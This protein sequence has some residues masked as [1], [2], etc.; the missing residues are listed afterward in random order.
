MHRHHSSQNSNVLRED[1]DNNDM[2]TELLDYSNQNGSTSSGGAHP[3]SISGSF[4]TTPE[5][6]VG[7]QQTNNLV[8]TS[9]SYFYSNGMRDSDA[10]LPPM[11]QIDPNSGFI[12][13][14]SEERYQN[15]APR[16]VFRD[17]M[18]H[19]PENENTQAIHHEML[20]SQSGTYRNGSSITGGGISYQSYADSGDMDI[21]TTAPTTFGHPTGSSQLTPRKSFAIK[22]IA[23]EYD[24]IKGTSSGRHSESGLIQDPYA[25][26]DEPEELPPKRY[27]HVML[28]SPDRTKFLIHGGSIYHNFRSQSRSDLWIFN[29]L[30]KKWIFCTNHTVKLRYHAGLW[31]DK[32]PPNLPE[33]TRQDPFGLSSRILFAGGKGEHGNRIKTITTANGIQVSEFFDGFS[34][35]G[36]AIDKNDNLWVF[37]G[38][39]A[40]HHSDVL[41]KA[42]LYDLLQE[43]GNYW[44]VLDSQNRGKSI[45]WPPARAAHTMVYCE[46]LHCLIV[47]GGK[48]TNEDDSILNDMWYFYCDTETWEYIQPRNADIS[49]PH[50]RFHHTMCMTPDSRY[51]VV[52]GGAIQDLTSNDCWIYDVELFTWQQVKLEGDIPSPRMNCSIVA[53]EPVLWR[54]DS[55]NCTLWLFGGADEEQE[56]S[57][58]YEIPLDTSWG[59]TNIW[60]KAQQL[61]RVFRIGAYYDMIVC[62][63][64]T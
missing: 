9:T 36:M 55:M 25:S 16:D 28:P 41:M 22:K 34:S 8:W 6:A 1:D 14:F 46:R 42:H 63:H 44:T 19:T 15:S 56:F 13:S 11:T 61:E 26:P 29:T 47:Y 64:E 52:F 33:P 37:A 20:P 60:S 18:W 7:D 59:Q 54:K 2:D 38:A 48:Q 58:L 32:Q 62:C 35:V 51:L 10:P 21:I 4:D 12:S 24:L 39:L 50:P 49:H 53:M 31:I 3:M 30:E 43:R 57:D 23:F 5:N 27:G 17:A 45:L 40:V